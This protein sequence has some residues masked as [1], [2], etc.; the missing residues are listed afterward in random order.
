MCCSENISFRKLNCILHR[1]ERKIGIRKLGLFNKASLGNGV[2]YMNIRRTFW[3]WNKVL[4]PSLGR[5]EVVVRGSE[6]RLKVVV[7][8]K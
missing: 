2:G 5:K 6:R 4:L 1:Q 3:N 8:G 7:Q